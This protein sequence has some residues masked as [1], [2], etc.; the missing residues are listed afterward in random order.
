MFDFMDSDAFIIGLE[1]VFLTFVIYDGWKF[2]KTRK[3]EYIVN[4]VMAIGFALWILVP[5]Y[6]KYYDWSE[7]QRQMHKTQCLSENNES[8]CNCMDNLIEQAYTFEAY[9]KIDK[10]N[11]EAYLEFLKESKEECFGDSWF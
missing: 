4:I 7:E 3:K 6:T 8:Y 10:K 5:Y 9:D 1:I 2:Y 11:D